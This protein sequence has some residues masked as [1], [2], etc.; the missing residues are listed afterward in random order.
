MLYDDLK[1][2][3]KNGIYPFH[4]PGHKRTDISKDNIIPYFLDITEINGFDNLHSPKSKIKEIENLACELYSVKHSFLLVNG[5]T[6]GI[7]SAIRAMTNP[8]DE[9]LIARNCHKSVYN[10]VELCMLKPEYIMPRFDKN[11]GIFTSVLPCDI[12]EKLRNNRRIK[13]V[14]ITSP[15]YEGVVS[16][17]SSIADI[18]HKYGAYL[19]VDEAHGAH[20][21]FNDSFPKEAVKCGAD[22]SV[23]SLHKTLPSLT[24]TALLITNNDSFCNELRQNLSFF[25]TSS[26]SYILM[27]SIEICLQF[28]KDNINKF[29][30]YWEL[31]ND[32][33]I[34]TKNFKHLQIIGNDKKFISSCYDYDFGKLV[35]S[36]KSA[37]LN[38]I[39][40]SDI[41]RNKYKI[42]TE[43]SY[44]DYVIAMTSVCDTEHGF[45]MLCDAL[46]EIDSNC[47]EKKCKTIDYYANIPKKYYNVYELKGKKFEVLPLSNAENRI[48]AEYVWVYPP[49]IPLL[50]PGE[51]ISREIIEEIKRLKDNCLNIMSSRVNLPKNI[52][53][54]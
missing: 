38:G 27:S 34:A 3:Y 19:L 50:V 4:M 10:A 54:Y 23:L 40:I 47:T 33:Y 43:L 51:I 7:L 11:F 36:A 17:I 39:D 22:T 9:V 44:T 16:D 37:D 52:A 31:L 48:S 5:S 35:I 8:F 26:P 53:V 42:E 45:K 20:F 25:E 12:E 30:S 28:I 18:C 21:P 2:Y 13:L 46:Y 1:N 32:F 14:V 29:S 24:Q 41:L 15:T 49:G 6:C